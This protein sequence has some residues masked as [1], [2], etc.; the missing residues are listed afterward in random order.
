[1]DL[2]ITLDF[3]RRW[4]NRWA[5]FYRKESLLHRAVDFYIFSSPIIKNVLGH[6]VLAVKGT[7]A[8][9]AFLILPDKREHIPLAILLF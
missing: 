6:L 4:Q 2:N 8:D 7:G 1:M 5:D 3:I 9:I